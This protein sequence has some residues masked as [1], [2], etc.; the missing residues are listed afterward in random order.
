MNAASAPSRSWDVQARGRQRRLDRAAAALGPRLSRKFVEAEDV[1]ALL[2]AAQLKLPSGIVLAS[3]GPIT[4]QA[5]R[6]LDLKPTVEATEHTIPAL[7][8]ALADYFK[9]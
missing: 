4:S 3:I 6:D 1:V 5:M 9:A 2:E 8:S 7:S